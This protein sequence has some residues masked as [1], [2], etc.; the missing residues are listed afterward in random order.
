[1]AIACALTLVSA[2][3]TAQDLVNI[4]P[5]GT[6]TQATTVSGGVASRAND[7][8]TSGVWGQGSV[9]HSNNDSVQWWEVD[10]GDVFT[11]DTVVLWSRTD[12]C[13]NRLTNF[14]VSVLDA[15]R[16]EVHGSDHFTDGSV[17][18][19][20]VEGYSV[21]V[22]G[23]EGQFVRV[24]RIGPNP[25][26]TNWTQIAEVQVFVDSSALPPD[27]STQPQ[28]AVLDAHTCYSM[29]VSLF[30]ADGAE[31]VTYQW[32]LDGEDIPGATGDTLFVVVTEETVG[33]YTVTVDVDGTILVSEPAELTIPPFDGNIAP[34]GTA[35]QSSLASGGQ[36]ERGIDGNTSGIWGHGSIT[37]TGN[38]AG[39]WW[40]VELLG[41]STIDTI[42]LWNRTDCNPCNDRLSNF[43]VSVL[44][45]E[46][47]EVYGSDHFTDGTWADTSVEGYSIDAGGVDGLFVR[48]LNIGPSPRGEHFVSIA[49][50]QVFG[51]GPA[52]EAPELPANFARRCGTTADQSSNWNAN[53][54]AARA[55]DG[56]LG[57]FTHT[58]A[59]DDNA[60][61]WIELAEEFDIGSI[62][63]HN[64]DNCCH[65]RLR[66]LIVTV[67]N[68][69]GD[70]VFESDL[71]NPENVLGGGVLDV[72]PES[73]TIDLQF[74]EGVVAAKTVTIRRVPDPD[75]SGTAGGGNADEAV[76]LS[77]GE[78]QIYP[79]VECPE[80][81]DTTCD[82]LD[83]ARI[84]LGAVFGEPG[85]YRF[86]ASGTDASGDEISYSLTADNGQGDVIE[87]GPQA[88]GEFRI[89]LAVG[90][91]T[92]AVAVD[93]GPCDDPPGV[94]STELVIRPPCPDE[95]DT[96]CEGLEVSGD[97][98]PGIYVAIATAVDVSGDDI[99][100]VFTAD[101]G[102]DAPTVIGP[103]ASSE[104][105]FDLGEGEWTV[106]V[107]LDDDPECDDIAADATCSVAVSVIAGI[108]PFVRGDVNADGLVELSDAVFAF[109]Y[110]FLGG[111]SPPCLASADTNLEGE[112]TL[113]SGVYL[114]SY[115]FLGGPEPLA[116][117]Q[118]CANSS[119][120]SDMA[121][122]CE[123]P[124]T[125][126]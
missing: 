74:G 100:Y 76:I 102:V 16:T 29:S 44:D 75:L 97:G 78:V 6:A 120:A 60:T 49:E 108:G 115:L 126:P 31:S 1:M 43:R 41:V 79:P 15:A 69:A 56:N 101:N 62:V 107:S 111:R 38:E 86:I 82:G 20:T 3:A 95:G 71:L 25:D 125:C 117:F 80:E 47:T 59:G 92:I 72:G 70:V 55:I 68:A 26:G 90:D 66:D 19:T 103:Q 77:L 91:W 123:T 51:E 114:L 34:W 63:I 121:L 18:N 23:A 87:A 13:A 45:A 64:R 54:V 112:V 22:E 40:Q 32:Q 89:E 5:L 104:A 35:T 12:C 105:S 39:S 106:T 65:S 46:G 58:A 122:G 21:D 99:S 93:D 30:N 24:E 14:R 52:P 9:T 33:A 67:Q 109:G 73:I 83:V 37:H 8:N 27:I 28:G 94:C 116:P 53:L 17:P 85:V 61:L 81:G 2:T 7:G 119:V 98:A 4:A 118:D 110:L 96:H 88:E 50:C 124:H 113:T 11:L 10:L 36:P 84:G 42:V 57:N 48:V